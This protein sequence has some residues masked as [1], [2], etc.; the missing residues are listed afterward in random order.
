VALVVEYETG[1]RKVLRK[2]LNDY[3]LNLAEAGNGQITL[4][5]LKKQSLGVL[6]LDLMMLIVDR[7][8][9]LEELRKSPEGRVIPIVVITLNELTHSDLL[10]LNRGIEKLIEK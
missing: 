1:T 5:E 6:F 3:W 8:K 2:M 9:F 4:N 7:F 10:L